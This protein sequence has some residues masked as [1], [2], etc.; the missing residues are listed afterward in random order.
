MLPSAKQSEASALDADEEFVVRRFAVLSLGHH[1]AL[2]RRYGLA[3]RLTIR[4]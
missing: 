3:E 2:H 4:P 1:Q